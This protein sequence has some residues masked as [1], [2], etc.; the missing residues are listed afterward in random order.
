MTTHRPYFV[1]ITASANRRALYVGVTN[2]LRRRMREH[3]SGDG[4]GFTSR[5]RVNRLVWFEPYDGPVSAIAREKQLK[6]G[7]REKKLALI[8]AM[9]P[10]WIDLSIDLRD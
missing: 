6:A 10:G 7:N 5:Y 2:D 8:E 1:Y 4:F 9:N 3:K